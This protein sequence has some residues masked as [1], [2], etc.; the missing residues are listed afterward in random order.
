MFISGRGYLLRY[1]S[2]DTKDELNRGNIEQLDGGISLI[3]LKALHAKGWNIMYDN[4]GSQSG[5]P[6][7][8]A[9]ASPGNP[10]EVQVLGTDSRSTESETLSPTGCA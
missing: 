9:S 7:P 3:C 5:V 6:R 8:G 1:E 2:S 4:S 10:L